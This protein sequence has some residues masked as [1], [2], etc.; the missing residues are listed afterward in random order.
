MYTRAG[1]FTTKLVYDAT[2]YRNIWIVVILIL[3]GPLV[4]GIMRYY[5]ENARWGNSEFANSSK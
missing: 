1:I 3:L 4:M 2:T 5:T